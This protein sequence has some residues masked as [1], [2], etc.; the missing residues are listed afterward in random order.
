MLNDE[1]HVKQKSVLLEIA[2]LCN[3]KR[4][5]LEDQV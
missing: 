4:K 3:I 5:K 1:E 2:L